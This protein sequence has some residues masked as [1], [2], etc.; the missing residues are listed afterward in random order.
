[1]QRIQRAAL[2]RGYPASAGVPAGARARPRRIALARSGM[3]PVMAAQHPPGQAVNARDVRPVEP[4]EG[5][6]VPPGR[7]SHI[8]VQP[9]TSRGF[10]AQRHHGCYRHRSV[11][12]NQLDG[13][14]LQEGCQGG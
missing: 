7:E 4:L 9:A 3:R 1:M 8:A 13:L 5:G 10:P 2:I 12:Y 6:L 11:T 14:R